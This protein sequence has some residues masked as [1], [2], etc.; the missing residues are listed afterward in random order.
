MIA[1]YFVQDT[2]ERNF[3]ELSKPRPE[4]QAA[5]D[6]ETAAAEEAK[7]F[8][9]STEFKKLPIHMKLFL[10]LG[11][12][13]GIF[14]CIVLAG[15]WKVLLGPDYAAFKKFEVTSNIDK[16]IGDN[17]FSI[18]RPMGWIAMLFCAVDFACLQIFQCWAD[19]PAKAGYSAVSE[20]SQ[21]A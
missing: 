9:E 8:E 18:I 7:S 3:D 19:R 6:L 21:S 20:G 14:S 4:D 2:L 17:V 12:V 11:L 5:I 1:G 15:P 10:V 13:C 16:V